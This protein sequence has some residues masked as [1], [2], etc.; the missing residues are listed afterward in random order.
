MTRHE[1]KMNRQRRV[2]DGGDRLRARAVRLLALALPLAIL[3]TGCG[4]SPPLRLAS[5]ATPNPVTATRVDEAACWTDE[6]QLG[7][8]DSMPKQY[9]EQPAMRIDPSKIYSGSLET[10]KGTIEVELFPDDAP[11]TVNNFVCLAEDGYFNNTPFHRIVKGFVIQGGD[12]TGTGSGG[13]GYKFADEPVAKDYERGTLA[14]ANA[15]PDTNGSQFFIVLDDLRGKLPKNYTIFGR[16][17][18]G[19]DVVDAISNTPTRTGR[20]GENSTPT[21]PITLEKV[22]ISES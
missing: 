1:L 11:V 6:Q 18:D 9:T 2:V 22:T 5:V 14:M 3:A 17:T 10:N 7:G 19:L 21:E 8:D 12:P 15:G 20:S 13:P 16:V 4:A